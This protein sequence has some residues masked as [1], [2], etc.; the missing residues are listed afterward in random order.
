MDIV[1]HCAR[2]GGKIEVTE[3]LAVE[4]LQAGIDSASFTTTPLF[5]RDAPSQ[6]LHW[7]GNLP[8]RAT[9][10]LSSTGYDIRSL[11]NT[12]QGWQ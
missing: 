12:V 7:T 9:R 8:T 2:T 10:A 5:V 4:D 1:V 3:I 6:P 11:D